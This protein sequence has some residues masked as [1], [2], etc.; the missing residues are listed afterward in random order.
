MRFI[1]L[2]LCV[3]A[4]LRA[5]DMRLQ[6]VPPGT[7]LDDLR[8]LVAQPAKRKDATADAG[9]FFRLQDGKEIHLLRSTESAAVAFTTKAERDRGIAALK[10]HK[11]IPPHTEA[12]RAEFRKG[13]S[14][15]I[16]RAEKA[17]TAMDPKSLQAEPSVAYARHVFIDPKSRTRMIAT[18]EI[19]AAFPEKT[20]PAQVRALAAG[21]GL[22]IVARAGNEKLNAWRLRLAKPK[23]D[24]PLQV[25]RKLAQT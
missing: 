18:D 7:R 17:G 15:H 9:D 25:S 5:E 8:K 1:A 23:T 19:L 3:L 10:S 16:V 14:I 13:S 20:T 21:A 2:L 22:Q 11:G 12:A 24:D 4:P 6:R